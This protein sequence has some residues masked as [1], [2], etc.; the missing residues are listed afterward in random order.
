[1]ESGTEG[2]SA[3]KS[4][5]NVGGLPEKMGFQLVEPLRNLFKEE[6]RAVGAAL[7]L[8]EALVRR[9]PF[10]G[11]GLAVRCI[12]ALTKERLDT[13]R[14][15]DAIW[16]QE[17]ESA[18]I[19]A[20]QYFAVLTSMRSVGVADSA[21]TY[22]C[23]VALRAVHTSDFMTCDAVEAPYA[24]LHQAMAR[25]TNEVPGVSRVVYDVTSK[26]P[27]TIEWE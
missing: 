26:P 20:S 27:G 22:D 1:V 10:P 11:P 24:V 8:P 5:H 7:G 13:L 16:R 18:G 9:Q 4:H 17:I 19:H 23:T 21:R 2:H 14:L 12:G 25:I 15:C 6:V 3:V